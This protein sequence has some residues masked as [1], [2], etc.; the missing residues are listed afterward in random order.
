MKSSEIA[1]LKV[2]EI[3][4]GS[5]AGSVTGLLISAESLRVLALEVTHGVLPHHDYV[6]FDSIRAIENDVVM[7]ASPSVAVPRKNF[8]NTGLVEKLVGRKALT[9]DGRDLGS[10]QDYEIDTASGALTALFVAAE[11]TTLGG[12]WHSTGKPFAIPRSQ[13]VTLG[14]TIVV[15]GDVGAAVGAESA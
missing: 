8:P 3:A 2:V 4:G 15:S 14:D 1:N 13:I 5:T 7:I 9:T 6:P 10:V 11:K 12:L